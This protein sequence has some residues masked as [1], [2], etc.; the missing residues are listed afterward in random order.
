DIN[1]TET[2]VT[3]SRWIYGQLPSPYYADLVKFE[4]ECDRLQHYELRIPSIAINKSVYTPAG[5]GGPGRPPVDKTYVNISYNF[6]T[7]VDEDHTRY[8]WFQHRNTDP[9][10]EAVSKFMNDGARMAF[11]EDRAILTAVHKG[12]KGRQTPNID[13]RL[14]AGSKLFRKQLQQRID[15]ETEG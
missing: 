3:V 12:M 2:G 15:G 4:G 5:M 8:F 9:D 1:R 14:D 11:E 6:L 7:P 13:L 10:D